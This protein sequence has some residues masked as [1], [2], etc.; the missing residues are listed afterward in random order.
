MST[1]TETLK[2]LIEAWRQQDV[3]GVLQCLHKDIT[4]NN[5]GGLRSPIQGKSAM[6]KVL[7]EMAQGIA[8]SRW[9]LFDYTEAGETMWMEG[10]DEFI[11]TD[12]TRIAIPYAG[13]LEFK[14]GLIIKWREY[15]QGQLIENMRAG[16]GISW[17]V[18]AMLDRPEV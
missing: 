12:G 14:D 8:E 2:A 4:W 10:V 13:V 5:S 11:Q 9:R 15:F 6:E 16:E 1:H 7:R 18:E 17:Q 3:D